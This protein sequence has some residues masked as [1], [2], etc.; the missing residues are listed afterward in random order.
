MPCESS[1]RD[2]G[3][4]AITRRKLIMLPHMFVG[5]VSSRQFPVSL[6]SGGMNQDV[7]ITYE[8]SEEESLMGEWQYN[9]DGDWHSLSKAPRRHEQ[10]AIKLYSTAILRYVP[11]ADNKSYGSRVLEF[12]Y[13][14]SMEKNGIVVQIP[15]SVTFNLAMLLVYPVPVTSS[16]SLVHH[17]PKTMEVMED[18]FFATGIPISSLVHV[19][20][21]VPLMKNPIP[22]HLLPYVEQHQLDMFERSVK[23]MEQSRPVALVKSNTKDKGELKISFPDKNGMYILPTD[24]YYVPLD[25]TNAS[26]LFVP[27]E[28]YHGLFV[29]NFEICSC[30]S[31]NMSNIKNLSLNVQVKPVND[32][33]QI[34]SPLI[35]FPDLPYANADTTNN[36]HTVTDIVEAF[37]KDVESGPADL[38]MAIF[39]IPSSQELGHWQYQETPEGVWNDINLENTVNPFVLMKES[40]D[41]IRELDKQKVFHEKKTSSQQMIEEH[42]YTHQYMKQFNLDEAQSVKEKYG[43]LQLNTLRLDGAQKI[44]FLLSSD[45]WWRRSDAMKSAFLGFAVWDKSDESLLG[46]FFYFFI[47]LFM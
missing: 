13:S 31:G 27:V 15:I 36:G 10:K 44:R 42:F 23:S 43:S 32:Q 6:L 41:E 21:P 26:I 14:S 19:H 40:E 7:A 33:P 34:S 20:V 38:G 8:P 11:N 37:A 30:L 3:D 24:N 4:D 25:Y 29:V 47:Y 17:S 1:T 9:F 12:F 45:I 22:L 35:F 5:N 18:Q 39:T 28:N 2:I 46:L 16:Y